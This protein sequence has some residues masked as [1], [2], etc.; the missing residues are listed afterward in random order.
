V[1]LLKFINSMRDDVLTL[2]AD[3]L[4]VIKWLVDAS[5]AVHPDFKSHT[6]AVMT[7]GQGA[8]QTI[9]RKQKLNTRSSTEAELVG[10]D[11]ESTLILLWTKL[12]MEAQ[13]YN[14]NQNI[15]YQDN[16][17]AILLETNGKKSSTKRTRAL[18]IRYFFMADQVEKGNVQIQYCPTDEMTANYM[19]NPLSG[20][21]FRKFRS[22]IMGFRPH[23][24]L[25]GNA[26]SVLYHDSHT[27]D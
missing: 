5:F 14:I 1:H 26:R 19:T 4:N 6:G 24:K 3:N 23:R 9:S 8:I 22:N 13:G 15:I 20:K 7:Y 11:N 27:H 18:N 25:N 21:K 16:K 2:S 17:S 12:F 10:V